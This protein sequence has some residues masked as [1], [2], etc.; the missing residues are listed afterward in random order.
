M[1]DSNLIFSAHM[2]GGLAFYYGDRPF[3]IKCNNTSKV[4]QLF[5][6]LLKAGEEGIPRSQLL[7]SLYGRDDTQD[8]KNAF[9]I[10][11]F[12]LR[13]LLEDTIIPPD[14]YVKVEKGIYRFGGH[15][16]IQIDANQFEVEA[17]EAL[18]I[19]VDKKAERLD[20][21]K[22]VCKSYSGEFLP[23]MA[24]EEWVAVD[25]VRYK[26]LYFSCLREACNLLKENRQ[27]EEMLELCNAAIEIY[28]FEEWQ[29]IQ[30]DCLLAMKR[31][32]EALKVYESATAMFFE[33]LGLSPSEKMLARFRAMSGQ[34]HYAMGTLTDIKDSLQEKEYVSGAYYCSYPSF[35]DSYRIIARMIERSGQS[36]FLMLCTLTDN[37]GNPL[38]KEEV[39]TEQAANLSQSICK[40]L[41]RGDLY[42]RYS[43]NQFLVLL[44]GIK[45]EDCEITFNRIHEKFREIYPSQ[46]VQVRYYVS[47][48]AE[49]RSEKSRLSFGSASKSWKNQWK[50]I[51]ED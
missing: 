50:K 45:Q 29:M 5:I 22:R 2:L 24:N 40:S 3:A 36:V 34:I 49:I 41:R 28:P 7:E 9:R 25:S 4:M 16:E 8:T 33:E 30:I 32:K 18:A 39:L 19:D 10:L 6:M 23:A 37:K 27:Y 15:L 46:R 13:R 1:D 51:P 20:A 47:S 31:Y 12:R 11:V 43:P 21:L 17:L 48:I 38:E 26:E 14:D 42:T 44:V 35:I